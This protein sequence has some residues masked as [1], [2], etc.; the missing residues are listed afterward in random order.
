MKQ[1][2][3][4]KQKTAVSGGFFVSAA[5]FLKQE[6]CKIKITPQ[7]KSATETFVRHKWVATL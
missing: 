1:N 2:T 5:E 6:Q 7:I 4:I 3:K